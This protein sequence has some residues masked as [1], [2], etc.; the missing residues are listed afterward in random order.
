[1]LQH[2]SPSISVVSLGCPKAL[3]DSERIISRLRAEGYTLCSSYRDADAVLV[4]TCGFV[5]EAIE[6]SLDTI[7]EALADNG[8]VFVTGCLGARAELIRERCP[9]VLTITGPQAYE[10]VMQA[11][12][13]HLPAPHDPW[14]DLLPASGIKLTPRH[15]AYLKIAEGCNH[16][17]SFCV[18]PQLRGNLDS[19]AFGEVLNE[20]QR[21]VDAGVRELLV[22]AQDT[23]AYGRD[24]RHQEI[25]WQGQHRRTHLVD[26][27][28]ELAALGVWV[29][30]HYLYP[31]PEVDELLPLMSDH[32]LLPYLD[33]PLQHASPRIL[34]QMRRP[35][36]TERMLERIAAWRE[37][38]PD[39]T[40][41]STF[42]A[43]FPGETET[44]FDFLL[45][46]LR[47]A[48]LDRVGCFA[49]SPVA[50]A[51][52][53]ELTGMLP[54]AERE[55]RRDELMAQQRY[56]SAA[57][58]RRFVGRTIEVLVDS[59]DEQGVIARSKADAPEIDGIVH[60]DYDA[61]IQVGDFY[62]ARILQADSYDLYAEFVN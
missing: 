33:I 10:A 30:L 57:R 28:R 59:V 13:R 52:A 21:L 23:S 48:Q 12:H 20:A 5:N 17:C 58:L 16:R 42:I 36:N 19:R 46:F 37:L 4:N 7:A 55:A 62:L 53:N 50:G 39:I 44:D 61:R 9:E 22:I 49:Y 35:A 25:E 27:A 1:M 15:Y 38:V 6:E 29:R 47:D 51:P 31:Y 18:I 34:R 11:V 3:V 54:Q 32:G 26:L 60:L 43:G 45:Q 24:L 14:L 40:I 41:R 8:K 2:D 56:I